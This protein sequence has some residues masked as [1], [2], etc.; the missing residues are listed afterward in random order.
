MAIKRIQIRRGTTQEWEDVNPVLSDG[1]FGLEYF[2]DGSRKLKLGDGILQWN[3]LDYFIDKQY[4]LDLISE[5][6]NTEQDERINDLDILTQSIVNS[7]AEIDT[8]LDTNTGN[9][10][11]LLENDAS[12]ESRLDLMESNSQDLTAG[13]EDIESRV[14]S[15]ENQ[16]IVSRLGLVEAKNNT[17]DSTLSSIN[18]K[19]DQQDARLTS[20]ENN[21]AAIN[22]ELSTIQDT[23]DDL[24]E[25]VISVE[26]TQGTINSNIQQLQTKNIEQD[27]QFSALIQKNSEQDG[28][29]LS[30]ES[31]RDNQTDDISV[32]TGRDDEQDDRLRNCKNITCNY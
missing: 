12:Q 28:R 29:L 6:S 14:S 16:N 25:R 5:I 30:L 20:L 7:I 22:G 19:D 13:V 9:I 3:D 27:G 11:S 10:S 2:D 4:L 32:I 21:T 18:N 24:S 23:T 8:A 1:E 31:A 26:S 15:I 17:Q